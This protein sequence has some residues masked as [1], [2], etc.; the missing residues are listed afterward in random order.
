[1]YLLVRVIVRALSMIVAERTICPF[2]V[3]NFDF[4]RSVKAYVHRVGRTARGSASGMAL[5]FVT[6]DDHELLEQVKAHLERT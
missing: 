5:S 3:V 6:P 1:M 4:P 2:A